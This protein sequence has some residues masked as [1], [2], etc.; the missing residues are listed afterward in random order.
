[1]P[2]VYDGSGKALTPRVKSAPGICLYDVPAG[3]D[4][5]V[6]S[7]GDLK[8]PKAISPLNF[9]AAYATSP[10]QLLVP[11]DALAPSVIRDKGSLQP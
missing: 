8:V 10:D 1:V 11:K 3:E 6:W 2:N 4:G 5:K 7:F 9:P